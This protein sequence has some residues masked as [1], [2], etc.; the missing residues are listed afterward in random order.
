[1]RGL[2]FTAPNAVLFL[3]CIMYMIVFVNRV[4]LSTAAPLIQ[5]ELQINNTELG[6]AF[7]AFAYPFAIFQLVGG[8]LGDKFGARATLFAAIL[9][10]C[11]ATAYMGLVG[12]LTSLVAAR[13]ALGFGEG[14]CFP[15]ATHA[16]SSW[17][18]ASQRGFA[19]G[20]THTFSR[21]GNFITPPIMTAMFIFFA[22][23]RVSFFVLAGASF[24]W[25]IAWL[26]YFRDEPGDHPGVTREDLARLPARVHG[27]ATRRIPW[28]RLALWMAPV[29]AVDFCYGWNLWLFLNWIPSFFVQDYQLDL[30]S[31]ALYSAG[32][33]LAGVVGDTLGGV[34]SDWVL[35][36][37]GSVVFARR[38]VIVL[39]FVG[40]C[41]L[42]MPV[43][44]IHNMTVAV[45][46]L[47]LA[48]FFAELIVG[49]IWALPMEI[50][51][52]YAGSASG[53]MN[54]GFAMAGVIS[55]MVFGYL[56]DLTGSW[57]VPFMVSIAILLLGAILTMTLRP[58]RPFMDD[59]GGAAAIVSPARQPKAA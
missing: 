21:I 41:V 44:F 32:I 18:P 27:R 37:T 10:V 1:M 30:N 4:N 17:V 28:L 48:F 47:S 14:P 11:I 24:I 38:S 31:S 56:V 40:G 9:I 26:W 15:T 12:G 59:E 50:A 29:T 53:M 45:I 19:Q 6:L 7:S 22:S 55:P 58:D 34:A 33:F 54:F 13:V 8:F 25:L 23:W 2:K 3:L 49:P 20:V 39:G 16:M 51:P 5:K 52:R 35:H 43:V 36:R 57:S 46:F 42:L